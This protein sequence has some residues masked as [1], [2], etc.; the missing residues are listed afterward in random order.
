LL[1]QLYT[2]LFATECSTTAAKNPRVSSS[3]AEWKV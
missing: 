1:I 3:F 2:A